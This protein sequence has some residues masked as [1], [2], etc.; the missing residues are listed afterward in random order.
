MCFPSS[1]V[2]PKP[3]DRTIAAPTSAAPQ[4]RMISL[5]VRAGVAMTARSTGSFTSRS[6]AWQRLPASSECFGLTGMMLP[7]N[8][9]EIR[10]P[11]ILAPT[12]LLPSLAP[13]TAMDAGLNSFSRRCGP[14]FAD[15]LSPGRT[16]RGISARRGPGSLHSQ[17]PVIATAWVSFASGRLLEH[18]LAAA[19]TGTLRCRLGVA[20]LDQRQTLIH[21]DA[22]EKQ[23]AQDMIV[24]GDLR[25][26]IKDQ[27]HRSPSASGGTCEDRN[28]PANFQPPMQ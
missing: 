9:P 18:H 20:F 2:S 1:P 27:Q 16:G 3:A 10:F 11:K 26:L 12:E 13:T 23:A 28:I 17:G 14:I 6:D 7:E 24:P 8:P 19:S 15:P 25:A 4:S 5:I 21:D 22:G